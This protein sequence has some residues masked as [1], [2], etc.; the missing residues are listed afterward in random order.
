MDAAQVVRDRLDV[1]LDRV[2][3][4]VLGLPTPGTA[5]WRRRFPGSD[6]LTRAIRSSRRIDNAH[7]SLKEREWWIL[8]PHR[9][10]ERHEVMHGRR[11]GDDR[12]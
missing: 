3:D 4:T 6:E 1:L 5:Q 2:T 12:E 7:S 10:V 8:L 11:A 9:T